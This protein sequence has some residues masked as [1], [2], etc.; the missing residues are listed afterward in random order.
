MSKRINLLIAVQLL[1]T[2][3]FFG[4][5][6]PISAIGDTVQITEDPVLQ[7]TNYVNL[8]SSLFKK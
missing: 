5:Q 7:Y 6:I 3:A 8:S 4:N 2:T 1:I